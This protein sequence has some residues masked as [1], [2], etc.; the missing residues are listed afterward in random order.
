MN[1]IVLSVPEEADG[2][3]LDKFLSDNIDYLTRSALQKLIVSGNVT[4]EGKIVAK[5]RVVKSGEEVVLLVPD[6]VEFDVE[7]ENIPLDIYYEDD[8]LLVVYK[9]KGMVVHP[10]PGNHT[11]TLVNALLWHCKDS[12]SGINGILR[13]GI[14]HRI[15]KDTSGLLLVAKNDFAH[16]HLAEQIKEHTVN[17]IYQAIVYGTNLP[18][19]G[20]VDAPIGRSVKDRKKMAIIDTG[21][22]AQTH[23]SVVRRYR[24]FTHIQCKL[25][26]GRTHQIRVHMA[27][28]G[29]PVAG[30]PLYG[31]KAVI[32]QL[33]GQCLH[34]GTIG[35]IHPRTGEYMEFNA[36]LPDYFTAFENR[37]EALE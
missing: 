12:L 7:A 9:P 2:V 8:D 4:M 35:F 17:R 30:D 3:R 25:R 29:H 5:S 23:F 26:T 34:A 11:G 33:H 36:P 10:A 27:S 21:R 19:E 32:E 22:S 37:L 1:K 31:P 28:L 13:P 18:E 6:A 20:D 24:G 15:D 16:I 14:V